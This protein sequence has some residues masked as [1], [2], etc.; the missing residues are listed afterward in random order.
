MFVGITPA[1]AKIDVFVAADGNL[2]YALDDDTTAVGTKTIS[3][4]MLDGNV[5]YAAKQGNP[6]PLVDMF[7]GKIFFNVLRTKLDINGLSVTVTYKNA[8]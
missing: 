6:Y 3:L 2:I 4:K 8:A 7:I 1:T 5:D